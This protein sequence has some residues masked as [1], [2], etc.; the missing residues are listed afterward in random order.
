[1]DLKILGLNS[2]EEKAYTALVR[3][4]SSTASQVS[5]ESGVPYGKIYPTLE[6]LESKGLLQVIPAETKL[7]QASDPANLIKL[8][9][10][11]KEEVSK[12]EEEL[13]ELR[14]LY[15]SHPQ[16]AVTLIKGK[17]NF[18]KIA[19]EMPIAKKVQYDIK[20][21]SELNPEWIRE[22]QLNKKHKVD[23][24]ILTRY[25]L[26]TL[27]S[28]KKW[29]KYNKNIKEIPNIGIAMSIVD[30]KATFISLI[31]SNTTII[32]KDKA[33]VELFKHLFENYYSN[34]PPIFSKN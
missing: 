22:S 12:I 1:M 15:T 34:H 30:D 6:S 31:K 28:V 16:E 33:A 10:T 5:Q 29:A 27:S 17:K 7:F 19:R 24:K 11:K 8:I 4:G 2:Y 13:K 14:H 18:Y 23:H 32:I 25:N 3:L 20:Y 21:T 26:E 9:N